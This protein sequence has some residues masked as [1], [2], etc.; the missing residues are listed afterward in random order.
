MES[1]AWPSPD[2]PAAVAANDTIDNDTIRRAQQV[3]SAWGEVRPVRRRRVVVPAVLFLATCASTF[4]TAACDFHP[5]FFLEL[6]LN[7]HG[8]WQVICANWQQ[9][10]AYMGAVMAILL[11]HE[12]GHFLTARRYRIPT[13]LPFFIPMPVFLFGTMGAV[14]GM[15]GTRAD[16]RQ[17]FDQGLAGPL[18]GLA[19]DWVPN[20][21]G[22]PPARSA[23]GFAV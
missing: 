6:G 9:G 17:M 14:I 15:D 16:R 4:W 18:A 13:S 5:A 3:R 8:T 12:M 7:A 10:V 19:V 2:D 22:S 23:G 20:I 21:G 11:A 1:S